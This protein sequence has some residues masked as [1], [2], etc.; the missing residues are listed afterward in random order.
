MQSFKFVLLIT[1]LYILIGAI[2]FAGLS[3]KLCH[4]LLL[5]VFSLV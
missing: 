2:C 5:V 1:Y 3:M 4:T